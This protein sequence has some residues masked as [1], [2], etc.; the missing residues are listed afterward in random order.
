MRLALVMGRTVAELRES[1]DA[2]EWSKWLLFHEL[3]DL[4][5]GFLVTGQLGAA[6]ARAISG[7]GK[8]EDFVPYYRVDA[9]EMPALKRQPAPSHPSIKEYYGFLKGYAADRKRA[10]NPLPISR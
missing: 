2:E 6:I 3:Y 7:K 1:M 8:A 9:V 4:P 5:D 10:G